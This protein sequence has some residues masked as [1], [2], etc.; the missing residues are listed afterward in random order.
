[1]VG[2]ADGGYATCAHPVRCNPRG[3]MARVRA[4]LNYSITLVPDKEKN[5][6]K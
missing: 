1:M 5:D 4:R 6:G 3:T 2:L